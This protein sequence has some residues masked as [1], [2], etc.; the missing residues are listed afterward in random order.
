MINKDFS[1][2]DF[3]IVQGDTHTNVIFD[4]VVPYECNEKN[5]IILKKVTEAIKSVDQKLVPVVYIEKPYT[6]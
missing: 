4:L 6:Q 3:R 1:V 2:H 5:D